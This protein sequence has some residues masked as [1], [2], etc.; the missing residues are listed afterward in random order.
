MKD[1]RGKQGIQ[2]GWYIAAECGY[3]PIDPS[4]PYT[5]LNKKNTK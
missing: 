5:V 4:P 2:S 1:L 3:N